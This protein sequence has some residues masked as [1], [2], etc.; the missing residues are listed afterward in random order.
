VAARKLPELGEGCIVSF[1]SIIIIII[2]IITTT[3]III[4]YQE[5]S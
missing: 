5:Q 1:I 3:I 2:I 4:K